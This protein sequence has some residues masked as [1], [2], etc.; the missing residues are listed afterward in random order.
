MWEDVTE[1]TLHSTIHPNVDALTR[2]FDWALQRA[3]KLGAMLI[4]VFLSADE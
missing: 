1:K 3:A 2:R 4:F